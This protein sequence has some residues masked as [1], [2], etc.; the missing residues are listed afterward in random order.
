MLLESAGNDHGCVGAENRGGFSP[1]PPLPVKTFYCD[2]GL[3][4]GKP[5][6][7][8]KQCRSQALVMD[9]IKVRCHGMHRAEESVDKGFKVL[10]ADSRQ[11]AHY[12]AF[13]RTNRGSEIIPAINRDL[14]SQSRQFLPG[15]LIISFDS[16]VFRNSPPPP[17]ERDTNTMAWT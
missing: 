3:F 9:D 13:V 11:S 17:N 6:K 2:Y 4:A 15:L 5:R 1:L 14:M 8:R 16:A 7:K 12:H 10:R